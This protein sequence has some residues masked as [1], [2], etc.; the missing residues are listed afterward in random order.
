MFEFAQQVRS[1]DH[2]SY[3]AHGYLFYTSHASCNSSDHYENI[4]LRLLEQNSIVF[5]VFALCRFIE[6]RIDVYEIQI[7]QLIPQWLIS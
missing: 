1:S 7:T 6:N 4:R 5:A 3:G 2:S